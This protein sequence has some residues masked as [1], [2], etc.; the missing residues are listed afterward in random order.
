M[1]LSVAEKEKLNMLHEPDL[2]VERFEKLLPY[3]IALGV[4]NQW[5]RKFENV[6]ANSMQESGSYHPVWYAGTGV[7][8]F[9]PHKFT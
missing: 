8:A 1:Y 3:A 5:G 9:S 6:L 7:A 2:T 4:E